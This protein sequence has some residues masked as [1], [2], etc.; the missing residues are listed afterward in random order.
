MA[1]V[2]AESATRAVDGY[3]LTSLRLA[4]SEPWARRDRARHLESR[5][6]Q[7]REDAWPYVQQLP[8]AA[9]VERDWFLVPALQPPPLKPDAELKARAERYRPVDVAS[10]YE[11]NWKFAVDTS[12][13]T[14]HRDGGELMDPYDDVFAFDAVDGAAFP[15]FRFLRN[16]RYPSGLQTNSFGWR[17][18]DIAL[19]KRPGSIRIVFV[20]A[21]TT[22]GPHH[23]PYSYPEL[24]QFLL[25]RW[26]R[27]RHPD[28]VFE[29]IN[30]GR[31]GVN[32]NSMQAIVRTEVLP[33]DPDLVVY[34]EG[35]NQYWPAN[36][37]PVTLPP[38]SQSSGP[39]LSLIAQ[40]SAIA[41]RGE[42]LLR[43]AVVP[44]V[45]P[46]KPDIPVYW[47]QDL[48]E[49]DPD[50]SHPLLPINLPIILGDLETMRRALE[51][52]SAHLAVS[53]FVWLV[54]PGLTLD[55]VR[56][57]YLFDYLNVLYWPFSY[58]HMRR[59]LDFENQAFRKYA[60][61][62]DLDFLDLAGHYPKD[63]RLFSDGVHMMG[64]GIPLQAWIVFNQ[65]VPIIERRLASGE[66]PR[67]PRPPLAEHPA[68]RGSRGLVSM[69]TV[70]DVCRAQLS[71]PG[72]AASGG[73]GGK[74]SAGR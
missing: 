61:V 21:S 9:G 63:P 32:S 28:I 5:K 54:Y 23:E 11:W 38:R 12:C 14:E 18:P 7:S 8:V 15:R 41:R 30:A 73:D 22:V 45:E 1:L 47:P 39:P 37:I 70:R 43:R 3:R 16:S 36:F 46:P 52:Q 29:A 44:G 71:I 2:V 27:A 59:Y 55:P 34:Y 56:D 24:I 31:E 35:S 72:G 69:Q 25:T 64:P 57:A 19:N 10:N 48:D 20:G 68:F 49:H 50:L 6:W 65:L 13:R 17:G 60:A 33:V 40:Y 53:S 51:D 58:A 26:G 42:T 74:A 62:H 67:K 66:W 4:A